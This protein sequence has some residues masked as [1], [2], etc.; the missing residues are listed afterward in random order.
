MPTPRTR[1]IDS[2]GE[3]YTTAGG[4]EAGEQADLPTLDETRHG[5]CNN[6]LDTA[7]CVWQ[8]WTTDATRYWQLFANDNHNGTYGTSSYRNEGAAKNHFQAK[9]ATVYGRIEGILT[10]LTGG[11]EVQSFWKIENTGGEIRVEKC[12]WKRT[13]GTGTAAKT[14]NALDSK[15]A[16]ANIIV[17]NIVYDFV[18]TGVSDG[19]LGFI[20]KGLVLLYN[21]TVVDS[22]FG[23]ESGASSNIPK[24]NVA[25]GCTDGYV[26]S[27]GTGATN[28]SDIDGDAPNEVSFGSP[29]FE[30]RGADDFHLASGDT[31]CRG[32]G[33]DLSADGGF[34]FSDDIDGDTRSAWDIGADEFAGAA[35]PVLERPL[36]HPFAVIRAA[37]Y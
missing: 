20:V 4:W 17:N 16:I 12:I 2:S 32:R 27:W 31:Q 36:L 21:N 26:G 23:F 14:L 3:D 22:D 11:T 15:N 8:G 29:S 35:G 6:F 33:T 24:N 13:G 19:G 9:D 34:A 30:N 7:K 18:E 10:A 37:N 25:D 1:V 28:S 5:Q